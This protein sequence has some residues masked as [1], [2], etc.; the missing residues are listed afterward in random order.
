MLLQFIYCQ[1][2][3]SLKAF[4][5]KKCASKVELQGLSQEFFAVRQDFATLSNN[6]RNAIKINSNETS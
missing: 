4:I 3:K 6:A 1:Q 5:M 2:L